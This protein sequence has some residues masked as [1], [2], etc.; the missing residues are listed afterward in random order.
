MDLLPNDVKLIIHRHLHRQQMINICYDLYCRVF[1]SSN[2]TY[3]VFFDT[4]VSRNVYHCISTRY[5]YLTGEYIHE[6]PIKMINNVLKTQL[7][8]GSLTKRCSTNHTSPSS[9]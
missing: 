8:N 2:Y 7:I 6:Q 5:H 1:K 3:I 4:K 9:S